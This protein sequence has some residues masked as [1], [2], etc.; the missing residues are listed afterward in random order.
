MGR[1]SRLRLFLLLTIFSSTFVAAT[2][3][4][5]PNIVFIL[6]DDQGWPTLG[7]YG[8]KHAATPHLDELATEGMRFTD[9]YVMPQCT[10]TRA[11]LLTGQHT[12]R[13][14]MWH[15]ISWYGYPWAR[16]REP[17]F[18]ENLPRETFTIAE[19]LR[20]EGFVTACMGKWH[21]TSNADG[22][23]VTLDPNAAD[24]YGFDFV[25]KTPSSDYHK[26]GDKGVDWLTDQAIDFIERHRDQPFFVYLSHHTIHGPVV[27]PEDLVQEYRKQGYPEEG[28]FNATYL[29]ALEHLDQSVGRLVAKIDELGLKE[30]TMVVF[31][32]D[33]GGVD[34]RFSVESSDDGS[35][36]LEA[37]LKEYDNA[38]L[39]TGKGSMYEGGIRVPCIVRWPGSVE[40]G[41]VCRTP[42]HVVDWMPTLLAAAGA[43]VPTEH[44]IDGDNLGPLLRGED[45]AARNLYWHLPL[46]DLRW[47]LTPCAVIRRGDYK[48]I[49]FFGDRFDIDGNYVAGQ[50]TELYNLAEDIGETR[51]LAD[52]LPDVTKRLRTDLF[53]WL[54]DID[55]AVPGENPN[56]DPARAFKETRDKPDF[57][58][59]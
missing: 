33:N 4:E 32:S 36:E 47:G 30:K 40:Q 45:L 31:L 42:I 55:A 7:C 17:L 50:K 9:A 20:S 5:Q 22:N 2:A 48:L 11:A 46:Y 12:A 18:A 3:A 8:G 38:P 39:R 6:T 1:P 37:N 19:G 44:Q 15:V 51:D 43:E 54:D 24:H 35:A 25:P 16:M 29:A 28:M 41:S 56:F 58:R 23:Y 27:A 13:N 34:E 21:L 10:P 57:L 59:E 14:G 49:E 53:Q 26:I 52:Q